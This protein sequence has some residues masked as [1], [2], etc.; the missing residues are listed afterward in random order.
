MPSTLTTINSAN[1]DTTTSGSI[2]ATFQASGITEL[3]LSNTKI[4]TINE[5][6]F[7]NPLALPQLS[8]QALSLQLETVPSI[9]LQ[10]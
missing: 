9:A 1:S 7:N 8:Y 10:P 3:D 6:T 4:T 5:S 2:T